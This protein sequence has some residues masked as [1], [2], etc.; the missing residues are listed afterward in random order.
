ME[1]LVG[2]ALALLS[3]LVLAYP[4]LT[5]RRGA[6]QQDSAPG[7]PATS[8]ELATAYQAMRDLMWERQA[9]DLAEDL[10]QQQLG[11]YRRQAAHLMRRESE[12]EASADAAD[13]ALEREVAAALAEGDGPPLRD[14]GP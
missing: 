5:A 2:A 10:Y 3:A 14:A 4:F 13:Q 1:F 9:G 8:P 7:V 6:G 12:Q 11:V